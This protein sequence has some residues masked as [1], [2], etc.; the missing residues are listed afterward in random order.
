[1][2]KGGLEMTRL[3]SCFFT[4]FANWN[5][6][7]VEM[8]LLRKYG[9]MMVTG[10]MALGTLMSCGHDSAGEVGEDPGDILLIAGD[11][12]LTLTDVVSRIPVGVSGNDSVMMFNSIVGAWIENMLLADMARENIDNVDEIERKVRKYRNQLI[13]AEYLRQMGASNQKEV[14]EDEIRRYYEANADD[15][16]LEVPLVKGVYLKVPSDDERIGDIRR[17]M[18][19]CT[20]ESIDRL[21]SYGLGHALQYDY[22]ADRWLDWNTVAEQ[23]PYRFYDPDAFLESTRDF[24]TSYNGST[25]FLHITDHIPGGSRIPY[26]FA[27]PDIASRLRARNIADYEKQLLKELSMHAVEDGRLKVVG[28]DPLKGAGIEYLPLSR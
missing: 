12:V 27:A 1:M 15:L 3:Y 25:Y 28:Y 19:S 26:E 7:Q 21:E 23:I 6:I 13:V 18:A 2:N 4:N 9:A 5:P 17:W 20:G 16:R 11:S 22:F 8:G 24:E 10:V 14:P